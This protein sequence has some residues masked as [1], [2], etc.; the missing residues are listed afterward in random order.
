[1]HILKPSF[2]ATLRS[3]VFHQAAACEEGAHPSSFVCCRQ[4]YAALVP[5]SAAEGVLG[6]QQ[7]ELLE[8][9]ISNLFIAQD[10]NDG[11]ILRTASEGMLAGTKQQQVLAACKA[12]GI[13]T[14]CKAPIQSERDLW[15][16]AFLTNA[17]RGLRSISHISCPP[18]NAIGW[19]PWE[20][21][22]PMPSSQSVCCRVQR[23]LQA[24]SQF[25]SVQSHF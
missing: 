12:L 23:Y 4:Q 9:F 3:N 1:M 18:N 13:R 2:I 17:V 15:K 8:G 14:E 7:G 5:S 25:E 22:L 16:E 10:S 24:N 6:S 20:C 21:Q 19:E 11:L